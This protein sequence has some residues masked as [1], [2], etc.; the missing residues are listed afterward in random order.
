MEK[1]AVKELGLTLQL[2]SAYARD[3]DGKN[4]TSRHSP[5]VDA[6]MGAMWHHFVSEGRWTRKSRTTHLGADC[7][8]VGKLVGV[9]K[10]LRSAHS[11]L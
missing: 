8:S 10:Q 9:V 4:P 1:S 3:G 7:I 11:S 5:S 2:P 6:G